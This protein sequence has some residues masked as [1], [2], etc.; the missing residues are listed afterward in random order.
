VSGS[1]SGRRTPGREAPR[2]PQ[3]AENIGGSCRGTGR[4]EGEACPECGGS[5]RVVETVGDAGRTLRR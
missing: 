4:V 2:A 1:E 5:G 3:I